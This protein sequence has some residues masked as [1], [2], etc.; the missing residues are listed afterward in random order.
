MQKLIEWCSLFHIYADAK[1]VYVLQ[2]FCQQVFF[3]MV[4]VWAAGDLGISFE[5][6]KLFWMLLGFMYFQYMRCTS[7]A[8]TFYGF[9]SRPPVWHAQLVFPRLVLK[10][11]WL[12]SLRLF[13][14]IILFLL[15][16]CVEKPIF[17]AFLPLY[18]SLF[19]LYFLFF[20]FFW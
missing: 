15:A 8:S 4:S 3:F 2:K 1:K 16:W 7:A 12:G 18:F 14:D 17:S 6:E 13:A 9:D 20:F 5:A 10:W 19:L 11:F